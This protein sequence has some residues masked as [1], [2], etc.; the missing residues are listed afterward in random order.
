MVML[1]TI[2]STLGVRFASATPDEPSD[3]Y[4]S[5][6]STGVTI[7]I[8]LKW[9][10]GD[11]GNESNYTYTVYFGTE[12]PPTLVSQNQSTTIYNPGVLAR[13]T[14]YYWQ[15]IAYKGNESFQSPIWRFTTA[16]NQPPLQS[17]IFSGPA[18]AGSGIDLNFSAASADP[19][20]DQVY[21][22]WDWGDGNISGW[23]GPY[24]F[25]ERIVT[26]YHWTRNGSYDIKVRAKDINGSEGAWSITHHITIAR[27]I[28]LG[29]IKQGYIYFNFFGFDQAYGYIYSLDLLGISMI[30]STGGFTVNA[31]VSGSVRHV[32]FEMAN[33]FILSDRW[34]STDDNMTDGSEGYFALNT[35][36][37]QTTASAYDANGTLIDRYTRDYV[38]FY[39]VT[40]DVL[41][42]ILNRIGTR[43]RGG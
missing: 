7:F 11:P 21:Y 40:F 8:D 43:L 31:S 33:R 34:A 32:T 36:L 22:Q 29:N 1:L 9:T 15:V 10:C 28:E 2:F 19:E 41:K 35:G 27:Q 25:G 23:L 37:Y 14:T 4:P 3:P 24:A 13:E 39:K 20:G 16:S 26:T 6:G 30:L 5:N 42:A 12:N 38:F 18:A 17:M